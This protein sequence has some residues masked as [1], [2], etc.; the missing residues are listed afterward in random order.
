[1]NTNETTI[2]NNPPSPLDFKRGMKRKVAAK[3]GRIFLTERPRRGTR[4]E[5][6]H[7]L[8]RGSRNSL[9]TVMYSKRLTRWFPVRPISFNFF[10]TVSSQ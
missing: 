5:K 4:R 2:N 7:R 1:M 9:T 3:Q 6:G 10:V 8:T